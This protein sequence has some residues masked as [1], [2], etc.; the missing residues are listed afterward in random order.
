MTFILR[1]PTRRQFGLTVALTVAALLLGACPSTQER[2]EGLDPSTIPETIRGDY[3]VFAYRC[4]KCHSL[5]RPL[6]S[7]IDSDDYW[8][9]YVARMRRQPSSGISQQDVA[10][11]LRFLHYFSVEQRQLKERRAQRAVP[12]A[13]PSAP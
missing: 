8:E 9:M 13:A 2:P 4:S 6:D 12:S 5:S 11:I 10:P 7:G 3:T 1:L